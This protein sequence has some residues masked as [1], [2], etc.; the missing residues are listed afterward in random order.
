MLFT[1]GVLRRDIRAKSEEMLQVK[2]G[3]ILIDDFMFC[4]LMMSQYIL[5]MEQIINCCNFC[6][7]KAQFTTN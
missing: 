3:C 7:I 5:T 6:H 2:P 1:H 4:Y